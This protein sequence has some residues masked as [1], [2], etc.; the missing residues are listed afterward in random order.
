MPRAASAILLFAA[1]FAG[2]GACSAAELDPQQ[3]VD[4]PRVR[5]DA[6][7]ET[8]SE[9]SD[10]AP[11]DAKIAGDGGAKNDGAKTDA[12]APDAGDY[13]SVEPLSGTAFRDGLYNLVS[14]HTSLGYDAARDAMLGVTDQFDLDSG[15]LECI[16]TGRK[17]SPDGTRTPNGFNTEHTWPQSL[18]AGSEPARS[19]L[20]HLFPVDELANNARGSLPFA[21]TD[22]GGGTCSYDSGGSQRGPIEGGAME[23]FEVRPLRRGD[24]A[25]AIFY[26]SV[27]YQQAIAPEQEAALRGWHDDDPPDATEQARNDAIA[28]L[29]KNRNPFVDRPDFVARISDY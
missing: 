12:K 24:V 6:G 29:Q 4:P 23:V 11:T 14:N 25:R 26:F 10:A 27:R 17:V 2:F 15:L 16:Y 7:A 9:D 5:G 18:G 3:S 21:N 1:I 19:D 13:S 28:G 20:H 22:C 8:G